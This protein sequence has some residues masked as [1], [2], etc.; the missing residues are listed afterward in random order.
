MLHRTP[1][2]LPL[3]Y[4]G[5]LWRMPAD[6]KEIY[7]TFDDGPVPGPTE[8]VL[9]E[10]KKYNLTATFFCI[11][12][13]IGKHPD[14]FKRIISEGHVVANHTFNHL[15]GWQT[16]TTTYLDNINKCDQIIAA[17]ST[18][19]TAKYFRPPYGRITREQIKKLSNK[20]IVMW[21]VLTRDYDATLAPAH[22]LKQSLAATRSGSIVVFHDSLKAEKN[23]TAVLPKYIEACLAQGYTFTAFRE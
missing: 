11:G 5:L 20:K 10:L 21:D 4:P 13:N 18:L 15:K 7:L 22:C 6:K 14:L 12:D 1:F 19:P 3:L 23:L 9:D 16:A 2:F 17:H 8:F